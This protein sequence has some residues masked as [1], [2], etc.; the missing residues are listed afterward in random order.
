MAVSGREWPPAPL[1][2]I[3]LCKK[4]ID[5]DEAFVRMV[6]KE[7]AKN[8]A[9]RFARREAGWSVRNQSEI[10]A[11]QVFDRSYIKFYTLFI[12]GRLPD[13]NVKELPPKVIK[14]EFDVLRDKAIESGKFKRRNIKK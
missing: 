4:P 1:A 5:C 11:Q 6:R 14:T 3:V 2:F 10:R 13:P 8:D 9:E 12:E 7:P